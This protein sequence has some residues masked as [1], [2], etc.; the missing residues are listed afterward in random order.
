MRGARPRARRLGAAETG[1]RTRAARAACSPFCRPRPTRGVPKATSPPPSVLLEK[2]ASRALLAAWQRRFLL[3]VATFSRLS[4]RKCGPPLRIRH[5]AFTAVSPRP[6]NG[7]AEP[8][9]RGS[10]RPPL[11]RPQ[12]RGADVLRVSPT[13][14]VA[15]CGTSGRSMYDSW[16]ALTRA[17]AARPCSTTGP[18]SAPPRQR[19]RPSSVRPTQCGPTGQ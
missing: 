15:P 7:K 16:P 6:P 10:A 8:R 17:R 2:G 3:A 19:G 1:I 11:T 5:C 14:V 9:D 12:P 13:P 18:G 4:G